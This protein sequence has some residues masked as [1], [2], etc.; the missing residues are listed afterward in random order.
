M[1]KMIMISMLCMSIFSIKIF[2]QTGAILNPTNTTTTPKNANPMAKA[3]SPQNNSNSNES[4]KIDKTCIE[5]TPNCVCTGKG[6]ARSCTLQSQVEANPHL[7][8]P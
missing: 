3:P 4:V 8:S 5:N 7:N 6:I 1:K 2:A